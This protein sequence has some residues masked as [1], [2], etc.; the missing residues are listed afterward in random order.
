MSWQD[1]ATNEIGYRVFRQVNASS[2]F[3]L[4]ASLP[5]GSTSYKDTNATP[6]TTYAYHVEAFNAAGYSGDSGAFIVT[7]LTGGPAPAAPTGVG[8]VPGPG[9]V[10]L[11]WASVNGATSYNIYRSTTPGGEGTTPYQTN[12]PTNFFTDAGLPG[13]TTYYYEITAVGGGGEAHPS[14][15]TSPPR[16]A[17]AWTSRT[18]LPAL[19]LF[20]A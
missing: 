15:E 14:A 3:F 8:A 19:V 16:P 13:N 9:Q 6:G 20:S 10:A 4:I 17:Q 18:D 1:N 12:I 7:T 5:P 11:S 2:M